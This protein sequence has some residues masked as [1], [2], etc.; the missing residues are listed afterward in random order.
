MVRLH[1]DVDGCGCLRC[2][3]VD[4]K[5][6]RRSLAGAFVWSCTLPF[7]RPSLLL[8]LAAVGLLQGATLFV[9]TSVSLLLVLLA[10]LGVFVGRGYL[11]LVGRGLLGQRSPSPSTALVTV[12][13]RLPA[14][15]GAVA[16]ALAT[17]FAVGFVVV[18]VLSPGLEHVAET[19]GVNPST[20][21]FVTLFLLVSLVV[22]ALLKCCF[23][24]EACFVG[25]Y[26]PL[27][28][29]R[30]SWTITSVH[31]EKA[32]LLVGGFVTLL[33]V[34]VALDTQLT[35]AGAPL[36]LSFELGETTVVVRSFG[37]SLSSG[38]RFTFD[39]LVTALYS[40]VFVHQYVDS[41]VSSR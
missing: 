21:D 36:V 34:G 10:V 6:K 19:V 3:E 40:G 27:A 4:P 1:E 20:A 12:L 2:Q 16:V 13:R 41:A 33:A 15:V 39:L 37:L 30:V 9:P 29:L 23:L 8:V 25:G 22:Y 17:L 7:A 31:T 5:V 35:G 11:G 26:G 24:P 28:S 14:F 32:V 18:T 38:V